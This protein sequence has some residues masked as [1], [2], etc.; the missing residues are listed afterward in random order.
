MAQTPLVGYRWVVEALLGMGTLS[1]ALWAHHMFAA[2]ISIHAMH[3]FSVASLAVVIPSAIQVFAWLATIRRG[4]VRLATPMLFVLGFFVVFTIGGLTGVMLAVL[5][6]DWQAHDTHFVVAHLHYVVIG[7]MMFPLFA[8]FYYWAPTV[9]GRPL[10]DRLGRWVC[11]LLFAGVNVTF[12][13][14]HLTGLLGMPR[15]V[16]TYPAGLGWEGLNLVSS[17]AAVLIAAAVALFL[18]DVARH[19]RLTDK[20]DVNPWNAATLEW[21]PLGNY[22]ARS[23]P[24]VES[25]EPLWDRPSLREEVDRGEHYLPGTV[26]GRRET[27]VT[28]PIAARPQYV[29]ILPG[30]GWPPVLAAVGTAAFFL[31]LTVKLLDSGGRG[32]RARHCDDPRVGV[33]HRSRTRGRAG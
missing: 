2:G 4:R 31:L 23:T 5:P 1:F 32:R 9:G 33:G 6:F 19:L 26:T 15:R 27:I 16:Y 25:R 3:F 7:G 17:L 21:L 13:P 11:G 14:M 29:A 18:V 28:S 8:G 10:S 20:V 24:L 30:P 12:L 22:G